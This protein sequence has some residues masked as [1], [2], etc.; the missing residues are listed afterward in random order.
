MSLA[1]VFNQL[2][3][4]ICHGFTVYLNV[5]SLIHQD[6]TQPTSTLIASCS[7][8]NAPASPITFLF[9]TFTAGIFNLIKLAMICV[10]VTLHTVYPK[11]NSRENHGRCEFQN[12]DN[13]NFNI[14][15]CFWI[16]T[17]WRLHYKRAIRCL[18]SHAECEFVKS[19]F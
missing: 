15:Q 19:K 1:S 4:T 10:A 18:R 16:V 3:N 11:G 7:F 17:H 12:S 8:I 9:S 13:F 14:I 5:S 2:F 6:L